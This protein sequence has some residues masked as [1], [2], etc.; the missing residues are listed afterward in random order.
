MREKTG[1]AL[2][3][4][5]GCL[6]SDLLESV[7]GELT[8]MLGEEAAPAS[9]HGALFCLGCMAMYRA[10]SD[11]QLDALLPSLPPL[12]LYRLQQNSSS[13]TQRDAAC[14]VIWATAH[15]YSHC[16][17]LTS[18]PLL[19]ALVLLA[20]TDRAV[21]T[22]RAAAAVVQEIIGRAGADRVSGGLRLLNTLTYAAL[23][24]QQWI[25]CAVIPKTAEIESFRECVLAR[26]RWIAE[27]QDDFA[28]VE[29]AGKAAFFSACRI[30]AVLADT[31]LLPLLR[32]DWG[33]LTKR[34]KSGYLVLLGQTLGGLAKAQYALSQE[35]VEELDRFLPTLSP[36][37]FGRGKTASLLRSCSAL[38][39]KNCVLYLDMTGREGVSPNVIV[40]LLKQF[41]PRS[42]AGSWNPSDSRFGV[43][44]ACLTVL[45]RFVLKR[46]ITAGIDYCRTLAESALTESGRKCGTTHG[47]YLLGAIWWELTVS[48]QPSL[49]SLLSLSRTAD[50]NEAIAVVMGRLL[51]VSSEK[52]WR[53]SG[54]EWVR[55]CCNKYQR[56]VRG[57]VGSRTRMAAI[58]GLKEILLKMVWRDA[59]TTQTPIRI[60]DTEIV[61][62][63]GNAHVVKGVEA[64]YQPTTYL[65]LSLGSLLFPE[66]VCYE[67][68][69]PQ[70][71]GIP[72]H[73]ID[74]ELVDVLSPSLLK[75]LCEQH[76][77][78]REECFD[79]LS[80][81]LQ[82]A[83][84]T[85]TLILEMK[86]ILQQPYSEKI[87]IDAVMQSLAN[88][89]LRPIIL[90]GVIYLVGRYVP[91][92][93]DAECFAFLRP[94][95]N[96]ETMRS[97]VTEL[98]TILGEELELCQD[99]F[100]P[101]VKTLL[102]CVQAYDGTVAR[103]AVP[104]AQLIEWIE[105]GYNR[106]SKIIAVVESLRELYEEMIYD[107]TS[108]SD[109]IRCGLLFLTSPFYQAIPSVMNHP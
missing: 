10:L 23:G 73:E 49:L 59:E 26:L 96:E 24:N 82:Y 34:V 37:H 39:L 76:S 50:M 56:D 58:S 89:A 84:P 3:R 43:E 7:L 85:S 97:V 83:P 70:S 6:P 94:L 65:P 69:I 106:Y 40:S 53:A 12:L 48:L 46:N 107:F 55:V 98:V 87:V 17:A 54:V 21:N 75:Q 95:S 86:P 45:S 103:S 92:M 36:R 1:K 35:C 79:C 74:K 78:I 66:G 11:A 60:H 16:H 77:C 5:C 102:L 22:R 18:P 47:F 100:Y 101:A 108:V 52:E 4:L 64:E 9:V 104:C 15:Y 105:K 63:Y 2:A 57:D 13:S 61:T 68:S 30:P 27:N 51:R 93:L 32:T 90:R 42:I 19:D 20:L 71:C 38:F 72:P 88:P 109:V 91:D 28:V 80:I 29:L 31:L 41:F 81:L 44:E 8:D 14:F 99:G 67:E 62:A 25:Y 33:Q